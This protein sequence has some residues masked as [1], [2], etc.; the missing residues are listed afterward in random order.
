MNST[1]R[2]L[3]S[4]Q[5]KIGNCTIQST[6][7]AR[8]LGVIFD[9]NL[10]MDKH[11]SSV[12]KTANYHLRNISRLRKYLDDKSAEKVIHAF[13]SS[14]LDCCN[15][16]LHGLPDTLLSRLQKV[17]NT[18]ARILTRTSY[19]DHISPVLSAL[20]W[21]PVKKRISFKILVLTYRCQ[22]GLALCYLSELLLPYEQSRSL[23]S[24]DKSLFKVLRMRLKTYGNRSFYFFRLLTCLLIIGI[25]FVKPK[26][27]KITLQKNF[28]AVTTAPCVLT[29]LR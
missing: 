12:V 5:I 11:V 24:S 19:T 21:L 9:V 15:A 7:S 4:T 8:N 10:K 16:L 1:S 22:N 23:R 28:L 27:A 18:A 6:S 13:I 17:Q 3:P 29:H 20:H 14:R 26:T 25:H 2:T